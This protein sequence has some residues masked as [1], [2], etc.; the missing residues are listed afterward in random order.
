MGERRRPASLTSPMTIGGSADQSSRSRPA[1]PRL[2]KDAMP[3]PGRSAESPT[4][5]RQDCRCAPGW[6]SLQ[7]PRGEWAGSGAA[8]RPSPLAMVKVGWSWGRLIPKLA[9][10]AAACRYRGHHDRMTDDRISIRL[11]ADAGD[12]QASAGMLVVRHSAGDSAAMPAP[13]IRAAASPSRLVRRSMSDW[14]D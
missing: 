2:A 9:S 1:M 11:P 5:R 3:F 12:A 14:V 8:Q 10:Q 6:P 13:P 4:S 7:A